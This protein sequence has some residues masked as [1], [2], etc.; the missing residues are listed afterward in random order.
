MNEEDQGEN[1]STFLDDLR[2][3]NP[4][5]V[6]RRGNLEGRQQAQGH[7]GDFPMRYKQEFPHFDFEQPRL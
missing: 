4:D 3:E 1:T 7:G 5:W 6:L 2:E